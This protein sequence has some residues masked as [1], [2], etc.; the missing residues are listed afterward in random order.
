V[1]PPPYVGFRTKDGK[2]SLAMNALTNVT[3]RTLEAAMNIWSRPSDDSRKQ[4]RCLV[5]RGAAR[6]TDYTPEVLNAY[7]GIAQSEKARLLLSDDVI[8]EVRV[9]CLRRHPL[10]APQ[11][12]QQLGAA[13]SKQGCVF[14][15]L[16]DRGAFR[17][18]AVSTRPEPLNSQGG[19]HAGGHDHLQPAAE[20]ELEGRAGDLHGALVLALHAPGG[21]LPPHGSSLTLAP[22]CSTSPL[23]PP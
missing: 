22:L 6:T 23:S 1:I 20:E 2:G 10:R 17:P 3:K 16:C 8:R 9:R 13:G 12:L 5:S 19:K 14:L 21:D 18:R 11:G 7:E 4:H 15:H